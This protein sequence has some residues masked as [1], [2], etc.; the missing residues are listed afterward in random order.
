M[1]LSQALDAAL[2]ARYM[3]REIKRPITHRQGLTARLNALERLFPTKKAMAKAIGIPERTLRD[4]RSGRTKGSPANLRK[5]EGSHNRLITL[6]KTA[7]NLKNKPAPNSV[8]VKAVI[9]W[10]GYKNA[11]S[12]GHRSTTLGGMQ[13]VMRRVI[14]L[15]Q[16]A[17]PDVAADAFQRGAAYVENLPNTPDEPGF[18]AE[19]DD[20]TITF[21]WSD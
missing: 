20:V 10:N 6:P 8:T 7:A 18:Q 15:W 9:V 12:G 14:R 2:R 5:I 11:G 13:G 3:P 21:P 16:A 17:G 4:I 1:N 19:G